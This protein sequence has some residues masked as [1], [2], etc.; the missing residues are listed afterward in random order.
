MFVN[1]DFRPARWLGNPHLQTVWASR[2][3]RAPCPR[4]RR[5]RLELEDGD[6]IDLDWTGGAEHGPIVIVL[7]GLEGS[8][9]S[10]YARGLL[11]AAVG[12]GWRG[13]VMHFRGCSGEPNRLRRGYCAG[14]T[15]DPARVVETLRERFPDSPLVAVGYSLGGN[16]LLKWLAETGAGNPLTAA[17]AISIPF[18]LGSAAERLARGFSRLYQHHLL[19]CLKLGYTRKFRGR[20]DAPYPLERL[21]ALRDFRTFDHFVTAPLNGYG[22][23]DQYYAEAS[24]RSHLADIAVPTL[25][26]HARDDPFMTPDVVPTAAE[27]SPCVTLE[28]SSRGGHVGFVS[29]SV[30][31]PEY[32]LEQRI[33]A[34]IED[35]LR[36][37]TG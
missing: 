6:F 21:A 30:L 19:R 18:Q 12:R 23:V 35:L 10:G 22:G 16:A 3:R 2:L 33:P 36:T 25:I 26:L 1:S 31:R 9:D 8:S 5:E 37:G 27:L 24:S 20:R 28:V 34:Y 13:V 17:V 29:G 15:D 7:H 32:W 14:T 4:L 11:N